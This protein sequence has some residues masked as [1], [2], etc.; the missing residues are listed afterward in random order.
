MLIIPKHWLKSIQSIQDMI[1]IA[2]VKG[3]YNFMYY[4]PVVSAYLI[5]LLYCMSIWTEAAN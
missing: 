4:R 5:Y 1:A 3:F 2:E